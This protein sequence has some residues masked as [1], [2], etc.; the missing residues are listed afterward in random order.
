MAFHTAANV[1]SKFKKLT[2]GTNSSITTDELTDII[3]RTEAY[4]SGRINPFYDIDLIT[5]G[6][7]PLSYVIVTEICSLY[8]AGKVA[9][10]LRK[11][12][13][14]VTN[15]DEINKIG[16]LIEQAE[17]YLT[18]IQLYVT[19]GNVQGALQLPD[20]TARALSTTVA[21]TGQ[22]ASVPII[23]KDVIQW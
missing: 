18:G 5:S 11:N 19:E 14:E 16:N 3:S 2:V 15:G 21:S 8:S 9:A 12:G 23:K 4:I 1:Q 22:G 6:L 7:S 10:I 13:V 17:Y 20:A